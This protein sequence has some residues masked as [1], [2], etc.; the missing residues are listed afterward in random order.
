MESKI[1]KLSGP[2]QAKVRQKSEPRFVYLISIYNS[3]MVQADNG[4]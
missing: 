3:F 1:N 4:K 2:R